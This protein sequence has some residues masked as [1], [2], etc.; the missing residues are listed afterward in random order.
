MRTIDN[1]AESNVYSWDYEIRNNLKSYIIN[2]N[3]IY[4]F[5][6]SYLIIDISKL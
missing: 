3:I 6:F 4:Y 1:G 2:R 5:E